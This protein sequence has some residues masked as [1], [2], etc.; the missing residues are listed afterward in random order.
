MRSEDV[1]IYVEKWCSL[2][3]VVL[4]LPD[5]IEFEP[6]GAENEGEATAQQ[7][8]VTAKKGGVGTQ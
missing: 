4:V 8:P 5:V 7:D 2:H 1:K 6:V 3:K